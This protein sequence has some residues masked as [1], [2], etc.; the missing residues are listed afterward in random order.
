MDEANE[1]QDGEKTPVPDEVRAFL[2]QIG[3]RKTKAKREAA[4]KNG[5]RGGRPLKDWRELPCT[6]GRGDSDELH[7]TT[8]PRGRAQ[9]RRMKA[10][11][12]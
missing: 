8:C 9:R 2:T 4:V 1:L 10:G 12:L 7:P 6:C 11:T 3:Q 5:Q